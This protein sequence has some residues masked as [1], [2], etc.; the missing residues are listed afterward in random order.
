[1]TKRR[2]MKDLLDNHKD[3]LIK[4]TAAK[5]SAENIAQTSGIFGKHGFAGREIFLSI[6]TT[7][8]F[9]PDDLSRSSFSRACQGA[10]EFGLY[11][12]RHSDRLRYESGRFRGIF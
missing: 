12:G 1:M 11:D 9:V 10:E 7:K 8:I 2:T 5:I 4:M 6:S 3:E